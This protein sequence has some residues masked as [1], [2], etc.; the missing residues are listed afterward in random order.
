ML[1][2][3]KAVVKAKNIEKMTL[4]ENSLWFFSVLEGFKEKVVLTC[5]NRPWN[6]NFI[7]ILLTVISAKMTKLLTKQKL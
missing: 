1:E 7:L 5:W 3:I 4:N 2:A 6:K